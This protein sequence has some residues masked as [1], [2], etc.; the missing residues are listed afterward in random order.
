MKFF[1]LGSRL[2]LSSEVLVPFD[3]AQLH[4]AAGRVEFNGT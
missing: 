1:S 3:V 2:V 4:L